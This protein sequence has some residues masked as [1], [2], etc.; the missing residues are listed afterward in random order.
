[1]ASRKRTHP[2]AAAEATPSDLDAT[3]ATAPVDDAEVAE[4]SVPPGFQ[5][6]SDP[7]LLFGGPAVERQSD[8]LDGER[9]WDMDD[10]LARRTGVEADRLGSGFAPGDLGDETGDASSPRPDQNVADEIGDE[11]GVP[12]QDNEALH[13]V[14]KVAERDRHRWELNPASSEDYEDRSDDLREGE[15]DA[16]P[17]A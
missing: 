8:G 14:D 5:S 2:R 17:P 13:T 1:M 4:A 9:S 12:Y 7:A 16:P 10:P 11:V 15:G 6:T 3:E